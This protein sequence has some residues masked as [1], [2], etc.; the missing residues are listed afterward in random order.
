MDVYGKFNRPRSDYTFNTLASQFP[1][2]DKF[3]DLTHSTETDYD[4]IKGFV[5]RVAGKLGLSS[6]LVIRGS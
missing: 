3:S 2:L 1:V 6:I 4:R 5:V